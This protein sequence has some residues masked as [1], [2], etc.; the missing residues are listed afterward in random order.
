MRHGPWLFYS[1]LNSESIF[2]LY[3]ILY[4]VGLESIL[5]HW[6][7]DNVNIIYTF[8][9]QTEVWLVVVDFRSLVIFLMIALTHCQR[10]KLIHE[11]SK[12]CILCSL[13]VNIVTAIQFCALCFDPCNN[14]PECIKLRVQCVYRI[15]LSW[16]SSKMKFQLNKCL[17]F[18]I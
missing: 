1:K 15:F 4:Y 13:S 12:F 10:L 6:Y 8:F 16:K 11:S 17:V 7:L 9:L 18:Y 2:W 14:Y 3:I 5:L